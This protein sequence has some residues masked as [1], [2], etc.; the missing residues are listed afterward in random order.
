MC[1]PT[2][3]QASLVAQL[4]RNLPAMQKALVRF[5]AWEDLLEKG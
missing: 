3:C 4:V 2:V 1:V 5:L